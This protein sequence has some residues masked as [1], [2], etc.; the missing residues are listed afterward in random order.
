[1][2]VTMHLFMYK[3]CKFLVVVRSIMV[4]FIVLL[5][6]L[7][8]SAFVFKVKDRDGVVELVNAGEFI[9]WFEYGLM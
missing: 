6:V 7:L 1:M 4:L 5:V 8:S 2:I 9:I 3:V